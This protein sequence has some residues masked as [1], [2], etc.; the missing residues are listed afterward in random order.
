MDKKLIERV[1][2]RCVAVPDVTLNMN[3]EGLRKD[4]QGR[5]DIAGIW[6]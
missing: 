4:S 3:N 1:L 2:R 6:V 5:S